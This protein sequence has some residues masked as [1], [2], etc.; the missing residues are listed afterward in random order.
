MATTASTVVS[1]GDITVYSDSELSEV[2]YDTY[3]FKTVNNDTDA[4]PKLLA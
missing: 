4:F 1:T 3:P 2:T